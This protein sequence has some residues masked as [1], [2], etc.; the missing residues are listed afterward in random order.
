MTRVSRWIHIL[1]MLLLPLGQHAAVAHAAQHHAEQLPAAASHSPHFTADDAALEL[2]GCELHG[3]YVQV[4]GGA[5][6]TECQ[7]SAFPGPDCAMLEEQ[8]ARTQP[9]LPAQRSRGPPALS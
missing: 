3:L 6:T 7:P 9:D 1:C 5:Y 2:A 4:L 8:S